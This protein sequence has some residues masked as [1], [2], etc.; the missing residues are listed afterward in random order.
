MQ[1][2]V[3]EATAGPR[4]TAV[5]LLS[6]AVIAL[7]VAA[8]GTFSVLAWSVEQRTREFGVRV[9]LGATRPHVVRLVLTQAALLTAL[10]V[11]GGVAVALA[12]SRGLAELL[13]DIS[14]TDPLT[15]VG[16][17]LLL[18]AVG[19]G[20]GLLASRRALSVDPAVALRDE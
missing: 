5:L 12:G 4:F 18:S 3:E 8:V 19:I 14:P 7:V 6:L 11:A 2:A 20:G 9:A 16:A 13:Y 10:G 1:S 15:L 17:V